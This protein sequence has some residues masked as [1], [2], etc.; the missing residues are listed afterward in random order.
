MNANN[1][2]FR[3]L[4]WD[5]IEFEVPALWELSRYNYPGGG[6]VLL[7]VE[8]DVACRLE[9]EWIV[10]RSDSK[11]RRFIGRASAAIEQL[12]KQADSQTAIEGLPPD[13]RATHCEFREILPVKRQNRQLGVVRHDLVTAVHVPAGGGFCCVLRLHFLPGDPED[14]VELTRRVVNSLRP[15]SAGGRVRWEVYDIAFELDQAFKLDATSFDIGAKLMIFRRKGRRLYLWTLS[16]ADRI[17]TDGV[18]ETQW[19]AGYLNGQRRVPGI[20]FTKTQDGRI[21]WR[22]RGLF[23]ICHRDELSRWCFRYAIDTQRDRDRNHIHIRVFNYR[24]PD[25]LNW[26]DQW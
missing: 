1:S 4:A 15:P 2:S 18:D 12:V 25:D 3:R 9:I 16:C 26:I 6:R 24:R 22:R 8:D 23:A 20:A 21:G 7:Q 14:P 11:A 10:P 13:W 19:I 5:G 17:F